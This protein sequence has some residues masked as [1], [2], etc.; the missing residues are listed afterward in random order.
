MSGPPGTTG[1]VSVN[2]KVRISDPWD[3]VA[4]EKF[5][6]LYFSMKLP[7][8]TTPERSGEFAIALALVNVPFFFPEKPLSLELL[9]YFPEFSFYFP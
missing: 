1:D 6:K 7:N 8:T 9:F 5:L 4:Q 2:L 3:K